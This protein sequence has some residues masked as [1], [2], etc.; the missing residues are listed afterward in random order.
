MII[1]VPDL[2][3]HLFK[4]EKN[5]TEASVLFLSCCCQ[6]RKVT[7]GRQQ[8]LLTW[9]QELLGSR[10]CQVRCH[11]RCVKEAIMDSVLE[12]VVG[13]QRKTIAT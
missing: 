3:R 6:P 12:F 9:Q 13:S 2:R 5:K 7:L 4:T 10:S 11:V 8:R 1:I